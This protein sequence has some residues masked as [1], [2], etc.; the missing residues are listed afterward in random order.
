[1]AIKVAAG[2]SGR[3]VE[4]FNPGADIL[5]LL[6]KGFEPRVTSGQVFQELLD[7]G[8][9]RGALRRSSHPGGEVG[10][11]INGDGYVAHGAVVL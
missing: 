11:F 1:M 6:G 10:F 2:Q 4:V 5:F 7:Q 3:G 8:G 9:D